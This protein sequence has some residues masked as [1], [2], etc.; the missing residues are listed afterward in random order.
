M[1]KCTQLLPNLS[2]FSEIDNFI[3]KDG[4]CQNCVKSSM[5]N[6]IKSSSP[7]SLNILINLVVT[8]K[9][10]E[11]TT[12]KMNSPKEIPTASDPDTYKRKQVLQYTAGNFCFNKGLCT[13]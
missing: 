8:K 3:L 5:Q 6:A 7:G 13:L 10:I 11:I 1:S 2:K 4:T 9:G 12:E